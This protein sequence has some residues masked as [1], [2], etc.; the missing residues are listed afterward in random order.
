M[1]A[2]LLLQLLEAN[3]NRHERHFW[4]FGLNGLA[5]FLQ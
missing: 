5:E 4:P 1:I 2:Y 3:G